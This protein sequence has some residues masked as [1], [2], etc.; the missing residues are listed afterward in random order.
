MAPSLFNL[1]AALII[2]RWMERIAEMEEVGVY[3]RYKLNK[4]LFRRYTGNAARHA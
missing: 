1:Y 4:K 2:E 3:L